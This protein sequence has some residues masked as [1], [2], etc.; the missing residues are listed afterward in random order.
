MKSTVQKRKNDLLLIGILLGAAVF[1]LFLIIICKK[2]G[3]VIQIVIDGTVIE[4]YPLAVE[5]T[6]EL[7]DEDG[8]NTLVIENGEAHITKADCPDKLCVHQNPIGY[9]GET[10]VCLPHKL[11][12]RVVSGEEGE[13]DL[14]T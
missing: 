10:I 14:A 3:A 4:S 2:E 11:I 7:S 1:F 9:L 13:V 5:R 12:I 8:S 6:V